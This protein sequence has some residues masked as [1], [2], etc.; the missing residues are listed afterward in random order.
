M[1]VLMR[2]YPYIL[3]FIVILG[4]H[5]VAQE[6]ILVSPFD[7]EVRWGES[8]TI[9]DFNHDGR[10]DMVVIAPDYKNS[11]HE[12][13]GA[14]TLY[15]GKK[16]GFS[17]QPDLI[18]EPGLP[19]LTDGISNCTSGD[20]DNDGFDDLVVSNPFYGEPQLD[21]GFIQLY[22][23]GKKGLDVQ[24]SRI[25]KGDTAYGSFGS[26]VSCLDFN[27][28]GIDDLLVESRFAEI[29]E[30][31]IYIYFGGADFSMD[32]PDISLGVENSQ[33]LYLEFLTDFNNDGV[34]DLVCRSNRNWNAGRSQFYVFAG[35][36]NAGSEPVAH[37]EIDQFTAR[38]YLN[39]PRVLVGM[40]KSENGMMSKAF[41]L[42]ENGVSKLAWETPGIP[43][44]LSGTRFAVISESGKPDLQLFETK[45]G[46]I[47]SMSHIYMTNNIRFGWRP[48]RLRI[49]PRAT[50][51]IVI[52]VL[53]H[54]KEGLLI[55]HLPE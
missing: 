47:I 4:N 46:E 1:D 43:V 33:S 8:L 53:L 30:G 34:E 36:R 51:S 5:A 42:D 10:S 6:K 50:D 12:S 2:S 24:T 25:K 22:M 41:R 13:T 27:E 15:Y 55:N 29:L 54:G 11:R 19:G 21:R 37:F 44:Q 17:R 9:A 39:E 45:G 35:G 26:K 48:Q 52:P 20:F 18:P 32:E 49:Y 7:I 3:F 16:E 28:D 38:F 14:F 23:G 40:S 31:R